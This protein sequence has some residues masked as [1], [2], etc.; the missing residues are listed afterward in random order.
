MHWHQVDGCHSCLCILLGLADSKMHGQLGTD[1]RIT[2]YPNIG[3]RAFGNKGRLTA[4]IVM[5]IELY[6]VAAGFLILEGD[7]LHNLL[8][9]GEFQVGG[10]TVASGVLASAIILV[11]IIWTGAFDVFPTLYTSMK[12]RNQ[13]S[14]VLFVCFVL[15][16]IC[17]SSMAIFGYLMFGS[18]VQSQI[19]LN[20][21][22]DKLSSR[23]A[24]YTT[25]V[26]PISKYELMVKPIVNTV[27]SLSW[28]RIEKRVLHV[29]AGT[30]LVISTV[31]VAL[32]V[33]FFGFLMSLV[34]AFLS[35]TASVTLPCV[36]YLKIS[37]IYRRFNGEMV[38]E[39][40]HGIGIKV[41]TATPP[42]ENPTT[43]SSLPRLPSEPGRKRRVVAKGVQKTISKTSMLVNFLPTG[44]LLTFELVLPS[45]YRH[46]AC[47]HVT[48]MMIYSLLGLC[49]VSCFFFHFTDSFRGP[50]GTV[51]Y[52]FV[53]P[54]GL[55]LFKPG[56]EVESPK[57][58]KYKVGLTDFIHAVMS[59]LVF[60]AIAFS[61]HRV[62]NCVFPGHEKEMDQVME[63]FPL[64]VGIICSGCFLCFPKL[65]LVLVAW[66]LDEFSV[67]V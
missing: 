58:D 48:T 41:Y 45:V 19:T 62:T 14:S 67:L 51:Y 31:L 35:I 12:K 61:D 7:N 11:S 49:A 66:L 57:D 54:N 64:M 36:C 50:D 26:N 34:G 5:N 10:L 60:M 25:L 8:P 37:G 52:G 42:H 22:T 4:S 9:I 55:A 53:T 20:L 17:Y 29:F 28:Y 24:I 27:K 40:D 56:L 3:E 13:F 16:T 32:A 15:C 47:T 18:D 63:G 65:D 30:T 46:G 23:I 44:T 39:T 1:P 21:P 43:S 59:V 2:T 6:L 33:P 38:A